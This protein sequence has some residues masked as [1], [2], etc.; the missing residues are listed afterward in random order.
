MS[1]QTEDQVLA[2]NATSNVVDIGAT[3]RRKEMIRKQR[4]YSD[5]ENELSLWIMR[6]NSL[7]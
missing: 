3:K 5:K 2:G 4:G 7:L 6:C 1:D